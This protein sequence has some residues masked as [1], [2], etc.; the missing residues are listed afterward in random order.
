MG[1]N[2]TDGIIEEFGTLMEQGVAQGGADNPSLLNPSVLATLFFTAQTTGTARVVGDPADSFPFQ[3]TLLF[4]QDDP[5]PVDQ[6][7]YDVLSIT[8]GGPEA[9]APLHNASMP[10]DVNNDGVVT[11]IDALNIINRLSRGFGEGEAPLVSRYYTDVNGD[12]RLTAGDALRV[13]NYLNTQ[14]INR[15]QGEFVA[16]PSLSTGSS[17][18]TGVDAR[19]ADTV[20]ADLSASDPLRD[21]PVTDVSRVVPSVAVV[22]DDSADDDDDDVLATL[23][24]DLSSLSD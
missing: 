23:A 7:R 2:A 19:P 16:P 10:A 11:A 20:F 5:V 15:A 22:N 13:I 21:A 8:V 12:N 4:N 3:D 9:E 6:I 24:E 14:S 17:P 1:T 18:E